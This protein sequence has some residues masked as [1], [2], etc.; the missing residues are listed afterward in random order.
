MAVLVVSLLTHLVALMAIR[1]DTRAVT[2]AETTSIDIR[3]SVMADPESAAPS[4]TALEEHAALATPG[5]AA[6]T[7]SRAAVPKISIRAAGRQVAVH[8]EVRLPT[9][10]ASVPLLNLDPSSAARAFHRSQQTVPQKAS[11]SEPL[12]EDTDSESRNYFEGAGDKKHLS[13]R[14]PPK[15]Q[16]HRDG[17]YRY[18]GHAFKAIIATDGTV[19][20]D[21]GY[22][23]GR[24]IAF[25]VT[26]ML[27]RRRGEDPYRVEKR[28]FLD[29]TEGLREELLELWRVK[30]ER[31]S[32]L[33]LRGRLNRVAEDRT[34]SDQQKAARV[35][36]M[37]QATTDDDTG[38]AARDVI[39][40]FVAES[41]PGIVLPNRAD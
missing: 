2:T 19:E 10:E 22:Q 33:K 39:S 29:S 32:L 14:E 34:L 9:P 18:R 11:G 3:F 25:D 23:Q 8:T 28:W 21:D 26:D 35:V 17:S 12:A 38:V 24:K 13:Q 1:V 31:H 30:R 6:A 7:D 15:L 5:R 20:F 16:R 36:S 37:Y 4:S 41:M 40:E 27:M